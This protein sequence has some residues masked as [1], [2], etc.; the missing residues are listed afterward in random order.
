[1]TADD[2][3]RQTFIVQSLPRLD[4]W[5]IAPE[6]L[7]ANATWAALWVAHVSIQF[8]YDDLPRYFFGVSTG[9]GTLSMTDDEPRKVVI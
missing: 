5:K 2:T 8:S 3:D 6:P 4:G 1:M 7:L 9:V